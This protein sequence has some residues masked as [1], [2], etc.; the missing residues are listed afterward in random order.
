M[1]TFRVTYEMKG[2]RI[3]DVTVDESKLPK[4]FDDLSTDNQDELL[5]EAQEYSVL[6]MED[7]EY[8]K[9]VAVIPMRENLRVVK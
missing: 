3:I 6:H 2:V 7:M 4:D 5:Y 1:R 8:G 9:G